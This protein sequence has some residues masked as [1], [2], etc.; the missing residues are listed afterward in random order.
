MNTTM[1]EEDIRKR[2]QARLQENPRGELG[3]KQ[4]PREL[5]S[6]ENL[7]K[8]LEQA[9]AKSP[10]MTVYLVFDTTQS[11]QT[12]IDRVR[13]CIE[14]VGTAI[15]SAEKGIEACV[16]GVSDHTKRGGQYQHEYGL[17]DTLLRYDEFRDREF[18]R[19][20]ARRL[21]DY[22]QDN[23]PTT[24]TA[25]LKTQ[26]WDIVTDNVS[27]GDPYEAYEC[28]AADLTRKIQAAKTEKPN[29]KH[30]LVF[31]GDAEPHATEPRGEDLGCPHGNR[32]EQVSILAAVADGSYWIDCTRAGYSASYATAF[33]ERTFGLAQRSSTAKYHQFEEAS[34]ILPEAIIAMVKEQEG[35]VELAKYIK[36]LPAQ[37]AQKVAGFLGTGK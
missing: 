7:T 33:R 1:A 35:S 31:F 29:K 9:G 10:Q 32:P 13:Q 23:T 16:L 5:G 28:L 17:F 30:V 24:N 19:K 8:R 12:Y 15:L 25:E 3:A 18:R 22:G 20:N 36:S 4:H 11:M 6:A 26:L 37:T 14:Q 2:L 34:N 27:N 21:G